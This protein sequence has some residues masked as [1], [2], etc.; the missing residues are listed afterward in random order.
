ML[1]ALC[2]YPG[3]RA[4]YH[5]CYYDLREDV[6]YNYLSVSVKKSEGSLEDG[7]AVLQG[8]GLQ[9][10]APARRHKGFEV[11]KKNLT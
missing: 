1:A 3:K 9:A 7:L 2:E 10:L 11:S 8:M 5:A 4:R 6:D